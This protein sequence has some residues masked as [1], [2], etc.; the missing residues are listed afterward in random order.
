MTTKRPGR[1][2]RYQARAKQ[3]YDAGDFERARHLTDIAEQCDQWVH[4]AAST[5]TRELE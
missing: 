1:A 2:A 4:G 5:D 3:A